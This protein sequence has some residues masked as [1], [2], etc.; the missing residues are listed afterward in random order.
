MNSKTRKAIFGGLLGFLGL[1]LLF[2]PSLLAETE[3]ANADRF[4]TSLTVA[5]F[6]L[7]PVGTM[8]PSPVENEAFAAPAAQFNP[9]FVP[10]S[11]IGGAG[12]GDAA[13][14]SSLAIGFAL[15][16]ADYFLTREALKYQ[17]TAEGNPMMKGI[18][19]NPYLFAAVKVGASVVSVLLLNKIYQKNKILG[20]V[21]S[22]A[23]NSA[24]SCVVLHNYGVLKQVKANASLQ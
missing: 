11:V 1:F 18:V 8:T 23:V 2:Q 16:V 15:N 17:G 13:F 21:L 22:A 19:K 6:S 5:E 20:W 24:L 10:P 7:S 14:K 4:D 3:E 12:F 9:Q